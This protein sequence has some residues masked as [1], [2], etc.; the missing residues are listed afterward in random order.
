MI[1]ILDSS[2]GKFIS[3][4]EL[5]AESAGV[6][7]EKVNPKNTSKTCSC[8]GK[9]QSMPLNVRTYHWGYC[10]TSIDSDHN[11]AINIL[12][13]GRVSAFVETAVTKSMKQEAS[14]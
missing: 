8:C 14:S 2:W 11:A 3:M 7:V 4:L 12:K 5:K 9:L 6:Q 10:H 13:L 1:N